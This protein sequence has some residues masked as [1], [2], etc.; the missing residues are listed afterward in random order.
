[1]IQYAMIDEAWSTSTPPIRALVSSPPTSP[2]ADDPDAP[3]YNPLYEEPHTANQVDSTQS[4]TPGVF[5]SERPLDRVAQP[6]GG[7][8]TDADKSATYDLLL[9]MLCGLLVIL[10]LD[11]FVAVGVALGRKGRA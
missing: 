4:S 3:T 8:T 9:F 6:Y 5:S 10:T 11:Q 7:H 1:M 2:G